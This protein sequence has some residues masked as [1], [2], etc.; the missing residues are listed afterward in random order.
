MPKQFARAEDSSSQPGCVG[1]YVPTTPHDLL[2]R[3]LNILTRCGD[4]VSSDDTV[5]AVLAETDRWNEVGETH[6]HPV[7]VVITYT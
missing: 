1:V 4:G 2:N 5:S 6:K 7:D 3:I